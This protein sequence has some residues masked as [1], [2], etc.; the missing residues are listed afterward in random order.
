[1]SWEIDGISAL[2]TWLCYVL[3]DDPASFSK[4]V[5]DVNLMATISGEEN[6]AD[7]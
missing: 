6:Y 1:M 4:N 5:E 7:Q 3:E 2:D